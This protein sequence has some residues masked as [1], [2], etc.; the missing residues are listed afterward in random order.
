[1]TM[2]EPEQSAAFC[3]QR[4]SGVLCL[5]DP[6]QR[7]YDLY[8]IG[9]GAMNQLVGPRVWAA[10]V[11]AVLHGQF[12]GRPVDDVQ[13]LSASFVVAPSGRLALVHYAAFAGDR[14]P[15]GVLLGALDK[16]RA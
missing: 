2:A 12:V 16:A 13:R 5:S 6:E 10:G 9:H 8:R 11:R 7:L 1:M 15:A 14:L 3:A 4:A